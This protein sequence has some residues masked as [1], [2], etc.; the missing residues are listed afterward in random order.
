MRSVGRRRAEYDF[1][2]EIC[3]RSTVTGVY[4]FRRREPMRRYTDGGRRI[5]LLGGGGARVGLG[6]EDTVG[7][8]LE[9][10]GR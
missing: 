7:G 9:Y 3:P 4:N 5:L 8:S 2:A 1:V 10:E 6:R